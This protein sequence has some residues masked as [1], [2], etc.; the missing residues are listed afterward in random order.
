M[1]DLRMTFPRGPRGLPHRGLASAMLAGA[2][3][4]SRPAT[5][6]TGSV[7]VLVGFK[8][9][10]YVLSS[11]ARASILSRGRERLRITG[12]RGRVGRHFL[13]A[14]AVVAALPAEAVEALRRDP[15]VAYVEEDR[16]VH[17]LQ[18]LPGNSPPPVHQLT[19]ELIPWGVT[20]DDKTFGV[21]AIESGADGD[22]VSV[23]VLDTGIGPHPDLEV[24]GGYNFVAGSDDYSDDEGHGTHVAGTIAALRNGAG[25]VGIAPKVRLYALKALDSQGSGRSS[26]VIAGLEWAIDHHLQVVNMSFGADQSSDTEHRTIQAAANAGVVLVAAAG[27]SGAAIGYPAAYPEVIAVG[28]TDRSGQ[29]APFSSRG[30][31]LGF[32]A[33]GAG[34]LS[35]VPDTLGYSLATATRD[36]GIGDLGGSGIR[37]AAA[38]PPDGITGPIRFA[39]RGTPAEIAAVDLKGAVALM[40]RGDLTFSDKVANAAAAGAVGALIY[41]NVAGDYRATLGSSGTIPALSLTRDDGL[42]LKDGSQASV[43]LYLS[44]NALYTR[45]SGTSMASPHVAGVVALILS[46]RQDLDPAGVRTLLQQTATDLGAKGRDDLYGDGLVNAAAAVN[47]ARGLPASP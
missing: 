29:V 4:I 33:P 34:I 13:R 31:A 14:D 22:G 47:A 24:A 27:N 11:A 5:A 45:F 25:L 19:P 30:P 10:A 38:T 28:A 35:T 42:A 23:G 7:Q 46:V 44:P 15:N 41:N 12:L 8:P 26:D 32:V 3:L 37:F 16:P 39:G 21:R 17:L 9:P 20:G 6:G 1:F 43:R 40:E 36:D 2:V 18:L